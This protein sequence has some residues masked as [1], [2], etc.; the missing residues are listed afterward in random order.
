MRHGSGALLVVLV[1][2]RKAPDVDVS[3]LWVDLDVFIKA[4]L[5]GFDPII[6]IAVEIRKVLGLRSPV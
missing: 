2:G 1:Q 3:A 6:V 4:F 5:K